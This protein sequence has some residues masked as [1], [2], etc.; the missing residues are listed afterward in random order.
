MVPREAV[1]NLYNQPYAARYPV[2]CK[3]GQPKLRR[4]N[5]RT[6]Q[7]ARPVRLLPTT[8]MRRGPYTLW[9]CVEPL[10]PWRTGMDGARPA[11]A[12][13]N[14]LC[15]R[16]AERLILVCDHWNTHTYASFDR[17]FP[18]DEARRRARR[19]QWVFT[20]RT[21]VGSTGPNRN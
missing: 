19:V 12:V 7:L 9:L 11:P 15:Y 20:P 10:G 4:T 3:D 21:A 6:P 8:H 14:L 1:R 16:Q 17:A 13:A 5:Q 2:I 18:P